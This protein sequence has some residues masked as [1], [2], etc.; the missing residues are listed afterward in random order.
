MTDEALQRCAAQLVKASEPDPMHSSWSQANADAAAAHR[1]LHILLQGICPAGVRYG[2]S[3]ASKGRVIL[4]LF[5]DDAET[6]SCFGMRPEELGVARIAAELAALRARFAA[7][8]HQPV[9]LP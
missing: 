2:G 7:G 1:N 9:I 4:H 3:M 5:N 8:Q 6:Q